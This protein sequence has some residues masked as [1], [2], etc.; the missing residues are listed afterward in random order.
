[1]RDLQQRCEKA[2]VAFFFK[3]WGGVRKK[4]AG[5]RLDGRIYSEFPE[6][7]ELPVL[8]NSERLTALQEVENAYRVSAT[9]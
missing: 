3:Q 2:G 1:V 9:Q 4:E 8:E 6:R 5:R 7:V